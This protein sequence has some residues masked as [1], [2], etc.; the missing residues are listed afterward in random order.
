MAHCHKELFKIG[1]VNAQSLEAHFADIP[2][3]ISDHQLH[4]LAI[5]KSWLKPFISSNRFPIQNFKLIW[6]DCVGRGGGGVAL[7]VHES[8]PCRVVCHT[9]AGETYSKRPEYLFVSLDFCG[10]RVLLGVI[11]F[12]PKAGYWS[13]IQD[14]LMNCNVPCDFTV[15]LGDFNI[16]WTDDSSSCRTLRSSL[17]VCGLQPLCFLPTHHIGD[18][19][20]TIDYICVS[21]VD[22]VRDFTQLPYPALSKHDFL[23]ASL[24]FEIPRSVS[25]LVTRRSFCDFDIACFNNDLQTMDWSDLH[26]LPDVSRKVD[27]FI[28]RLTQLYDVHAPYQVFTPRKRRSPWITDGLRE[29]IRARNRAWTVYRRYKRESDHAA[30]KRLRGHVRRA[31]HQAM[32]TYYRDRLV[33]SRSATEM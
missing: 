29:L 10:A 5:S 6:S 7:Y 8:I 31:S 25:R 32:T 2:S 23:S 19:H 17:T 24:L 11:Y 3:L 33:K 1:H 9:M 28:E 27:C 26:G 4:L 16:N 12:P 14:V 20:T 13:D 21:D 15:L 30:Y 18:L 22:R